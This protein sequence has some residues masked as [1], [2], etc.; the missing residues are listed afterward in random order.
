MR[1][2]DNDLED[3]EEKL[4]LRSRLTIE[5]AKCIIQEY[6]EEF[7]EKIELVNK[8]KTEGLKDYE[9]VIEEPRT[10]GEYSYQNLDF[11]SLTKIEFE[12]LL[13][14]HPYLREIRSFDRRYHLAHVYLEIKK[15]QREGTLPDETKEHLANKYDISNSQLSEY[16]LERKIPLLLRMLD[17]HEKAR[18]QHDAKFSPKIVK[19]RV[20]SE[21]VYEKLNRFKDNEDISITEFTKSICEILDESD[22]TSKIRWFEL[23]PYH[24]DSG[25][26]WL[27]VLEKFVE[28]NRI[29][30]ETELNK[31]SHKQGNTQH[32]IRLGI[33]DNKI[34]IR[35]CNIDEL[36]WMNLY[37]KE[38]FHFRHPNQKSILLDEAK[39]RLGVGLTYFGRLVG[40][41]TDYN[42]TI[43]EG[44]GENA[45]L[46]HRIHHLKGSTLHLILDTC[47]LQIQD[48]E[49]EIRF[50]GRSDRHGIKN[51]QFVKDKKQI[52]KAFARFFGGG[53]SDGT[54][55]E[56][57]VF[58]YY[59]SHK[60]RIDI[61][62]EYFKF[63]GNTD[64][65][66]RR[67]KDNTI[68]I[69]FPSVVGRLLESLSFPV[70]DKSIQNFGLPSFIKF[71][72]IDVLCEYLRQLWAEDGTFVSYRYRGRKLRTF[73]SW[74][75]SKTLYDPTKEEKHELLSEI[76]PNHIQFI[77]KYGRYKKD[78]VGTRYILLGG[79]L[80][81][82]AK[83][84]NRQTA[85]IAR[86]LLD[87]VETNK[88]RLMIDEQIILKKFNAQTN[89]RCAWVTLYLG[90]G[91]LS[92]LW[93]A[94]SATL[95]DA[96]R[97]ALM[98]PPDDIRKLSKVQNWICFDTTRYHRILHELVNKGLSPTLID[99]S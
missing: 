56:H 94:R 3:V 15:I 71:G 23:R 52:H 63:L 31:E 36:H 33:I 26:K 92:A 38:M 93:R 77:Q 64:F 39:N 16:L 22:T 57:R 12:E 90:T 49:S 80:D 74:T 17:N 82:L 53:L 81:Q 24:K 28:R 19:H 83:S 51:P 60:E 47:N 98:S 35:T 40:Q 65:T 67:C 2:F 11:P 43:F 4:H 88:P 48:I 10:L 66:E 14:R 42:R 9:P 91:R 54:I 44:R 46:Q 13:N 97:I 32:H 95:D 62:K 76:S 27:E 72:D 96:M 99:L 5:E 50:I 8:I 89:E 86:S 20:E 41:I 7:N 69:R 59:D 73:F 58:S 37:S 6:N 25:P 29:A 75:R 1:E 30:I 55:D 45:D 87:I 85:E 79:R 61:Y 34:Y 78:I 70:G 84:S 68:N 18:Y 21:L